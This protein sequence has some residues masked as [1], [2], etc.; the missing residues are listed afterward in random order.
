MSRRPSSRSRYT[1]AHSGHLL[2][3]I[4]EGYAAHQSF[5]AE[6]AVVVV[7]QQQAGGGVAGNENVRPTIVIHVERGCGQAI[8]AVQRAYSRFLRYIG[9]AAISVV[10][11]EQMA[12]QRQSAG[13]Q[14]TGTPSKLQLGRSRDG[15]GIVARSTSA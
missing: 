14:F 9:K 4:V 13:P 11:V 15:L 2:A 1:H 10:A 6:S 8:R 12:W 5:L 3:G 7:H